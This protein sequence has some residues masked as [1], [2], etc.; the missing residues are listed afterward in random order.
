MQKYVVSDWKAWSVF[1]K[2]FAGM[3]HWILHK[4]A[5][6]PFLMP[7]CSKENRD[8]LVS[9]CC[10]LGYSKPRKVQRSLVILW[11]S[12]A[13]IFLPQKP[14]WNQRKEDMTSCHSDNLY[15][16]ITFQGRESRI[17]AKPSGKSKLVIMAHLAGYK[18]VSC[19]FNAR[20]V[21]GGYFNY[22]ECSVL[23]N[24]LYT[25]CTHRYF[26]HWAICLLCVHPSWSWN[27]S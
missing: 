26:A 7:K 14:V 27:V 2:Q 20:R 8:S 24:T 1:L 3:Q 9:S 15:T 4:L 5:P 21:K 6:S 16:L 11:T 22:Q 13:T 12:R 10:D 19:Q 23:S 18:L 25:H 17:L